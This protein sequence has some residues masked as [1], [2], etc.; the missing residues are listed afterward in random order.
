MG[1]AWRH[2]T[3]QALVSPAYDMAQLSSR[4]QEL[5]HG[6]CLMDTHT[7][8]VHTEMRYIM[9]NPSPTWSAAFL[10]PLPNHL[11]PASAAAS[12]TRT[13]SRARLRCT[14]R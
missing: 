3:A 2:C 12:V 10:S 13:S 7:G 9:Q 6:C 11:P 4:Q 14:A 8:D 5:P 1:Q